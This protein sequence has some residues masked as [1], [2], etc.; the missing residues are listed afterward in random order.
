MFHRNYLTDGPDPT[1][2]TSHSWTDLMRRN[3]GWVSTIQ[4]YGLVLCKPFLQYSGTGVCSPL[5]FDSVQY[6]LTRRY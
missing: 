5:S 3:H 4:F 6:D 2:R 1:L